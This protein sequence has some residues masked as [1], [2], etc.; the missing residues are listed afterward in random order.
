MAQG[1]AFKN[2]TVFYAINLASS[3]QSVSDTVQRV[4]WS[5]NVQFGNWYYW[6]LRLHVAV[7]G[8][9]VGSWTGACTYRGQVV[10]NVSGSRDIAKGASGRSVQV[11]A[12]TTSETVNG[13]GGVGTTTSCAENQ[14]VPGIQYRTP[15]TPTGISVRRDSDSSIGVSWQNHPEGVSKHYTGV[16]V[17][18][19]ADGGGWAVIANLG[20][21]DS[22]YTDTSVSV[23]HRYAYRVRAKNEAGWSGYAIS[24]WVYTTPAAP[25][26][27]SVSRRSDSQMYVAWSLGANAGASYIN[28]LL[29]RQ[30]DGGQWSQIATLGA[31][32]T[33]YTDNGSSANH[34]YAYRVRAYNGLYSG[35][36]VSGI[37]YTT[38][39]APRSVSLA[40]V[41]GTVVRIT[42]DSA[43]PYADD[44]RYQLS[45]NGGAWGAEA[46]M[47][48]SVEVDAGGG[49]I[50]ARVR[51]RKGD[52]Y[53]G[54]RESNEVTTIVEPSAPTL[55]ALSTVYA[56][57]ARVE[58]TWTRNH[59]DGTDQT[60]AQ[61]ELMDPSGDS[62]VTD[63]AGSASSTALQ[64]AS[65][66]DWQVRVRT[67]GVA[68][69]WGAWSPWSVFHAETAPNAYFTEPSTDGLI[70]AGVPLEL[71]WRVDTSSG[72]SS[73]LL[74]VY[75]EY[76]GQ[77]YRAEL[78]VDVRSFE[79]SADTYLP[80]TM[81]NYVVELFARDGYS[82][83]STARRLFATDYAE[84]AMPYVE[85]ENDP[86]DMSAHIR[87]I[88]GEGGWE[89]NEE[90]RLVSPEIWDGSETRVKVTAGFLD[91]AY[92]GLVGIGVVVPTERIS[93]SRQLPDGAQGVVSSDLADDSWAIDRLPPLNTEYSYVVTAY[94]ATGTATSV[95]VPAYIDSDGQEAF[96]FGS[97]ASTAIL[98]GFEAESS[99][100]L[101]STGESFHFALGP[102]T[103]PLPTFYPDGSADATGRKGYSVISVDEYRR[104]DA[105]RRARGNAVCWM[106][107][108]WGGRHRVLANWTL[109]Y[110]ASEYSKWT[111]DA[112]I[113]EVVWEEPVN[114]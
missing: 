78:G 109:G 88:Q 106:R 19:S 82:L 69:G 81:S 72:V 67:K 37:A 111:A 1:V 15:N 105:I 49:T 21:T 47:G 9:E 65:E 66:G 58:V 2:G 5:C 62:A 80:Q 33:N 55:S 35:Y 114:G 12:W 23:H 34:S 24:G 59:P 13:Y 95:N 71:R 4:N 64:V 18:R 46:V 91:T 25:S 98:L 60:A 30:I 100:A 39:A 113:T 10:I 107:D 89:L 108:Y 102:A 61:V 20:G 68:E 26:G 56:I 99:S 63:I 112:D 93:V 17:E 90:G 77:L 51:A 92:E 54:Y 110:S 74:T 86:S 29:E 87:V 75:D 16:S 73:Q 50:E 6:G 104:L 7:D 57:P 14:T 42:V 38:P 83:E 94:S 52:L 27:C 76:G 41:S 103:E 22:S 43:S 96:N 31:D 79:L 11:S 44:Y 101:A 8:V 36:S 45:V 28:V 97:D 32:V 53:S 48:T 3:S 70:V 84:P 40:K 85:V